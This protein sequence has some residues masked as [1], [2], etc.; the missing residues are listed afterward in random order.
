MAASVR[1]TLLAGALLLLLVA[2]AVVAFEDVCTRAH[3]LKW[4][5]LVVWLGVRGFL[6]VVSHKFARG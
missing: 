3:A 1:T 2:V 4:L 5:R 6:G